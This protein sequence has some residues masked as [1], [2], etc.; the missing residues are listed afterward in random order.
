MID[1]TALKTAGE[2]VMDYATTSTRKVVETNVAILKDWVELN[3]M[4][5]DMHPAKAVFG[6]FTP[7]KK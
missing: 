5:W 4:L 3:K 6:S 2:A 1:N 7:P